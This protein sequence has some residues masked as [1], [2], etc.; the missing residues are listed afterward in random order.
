M[1]PSREVVVAVVVGE[2]EI[3]LA[4]GAKKQNRKQGQG[5]R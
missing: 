4:Y 2:M 5:S 1:I 3:K